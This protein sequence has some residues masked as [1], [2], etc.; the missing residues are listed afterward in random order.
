MKKWILLFL[1]IPSLV[2]A[3]TITISNTGG[4]AGDVTS[5]GDCVS[6]A[7]LDGSS[8]GGTYLRLYDGD[9]HYN[10]L[11][12]PNISGNV[13]ITLPN[14]TGTVL[15]TTGNAA[16]A[17]ALA[18]NGGNCSAG[19]YPLGV[20]ASGAVESC[21]DATTEI[22]SA[23]ATHMAIVTDTSTIGHLN[24]T[25][26]DTFNGKQ[27]ALGF[28]PV[29][30]ADWTT[31]NSYP[32]ACTAGYYAH[33]IGDT[34]SCTDATTEINSVVNGLG[35]TGLTCS[36]Q[37]CDVDL[38]TSIATTELVSPTGADTNVV[39]GTKGS[40]D[41]CAKWNADGDL[42][43]AGAACG[44]GGSGDL[45][46]DAVDAD[47]LPTGADNTYD[48]GSSAASFADIHWDGTATGNVTGNIT[49]NVSGSSG[50]VTTITGLA[51][52]TQNTYARTQYLI[53]VASSTTAFGEIDIGTATHVLT[54]NGAGSA[55]TFQASSGATAYDDIGDP[56][57]NSTI[58]FGDYT[59]TWTTNEAS[60]D[61]FIIQNSGTFGDVS[62]V[63]IE[64]TGNATDGTML[65]IVNTD[66]DV[67]SI[68]APNFTVT[69]PGVVTALEYHG[70][71]SNLTGLSSS[72]G[73]FFHLLPQ[74]GKLPSTDMMAIDAGN[75]QWRGLFDDT[76]DECARWQTT[77]TPYNGGTLQGEIL[78]SLE[79]TSS[80]DVVGIEIYIMCVTGGDAADVDTDSFGTVNDLASG[81]VSTTAG[82]LVK[83][84]DASLNGDS[85]A[86]D[87]LIIVKVCRDAD[88]VDT[89]TDDVEF[90]GGVI[91]E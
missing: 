76:T 73:F 63:K 5:V 50:T 48:L 90:R 40:T 38:G 59:N 24:D 75:N 83:L 8:D 20:D 46:S 30:S 35:G 10:A 67:D 78:Y 15:L 3:G 27:A 25:D 85:C 68:I 79:T 60:S 14:S 62:V 84:S 21:T 77:L 72:A 2:C 4:G 42:V 31:N 44:S 45:W 6:G 9:S 18:A 70:D 54:S 82:Y 12:S 41:D 86:E 81:S 16:T 87:D 1:L 56:D 17:T 51:P 34:L 71:G 53:P 57:A 74:Q 36:G 66:A 55:P 61:F 7:C 26:W 49:G 39:T 11:V 91:Y 29:N 52:D 69:Q 47:I 22:G 58:V 32:A 88:G 37:N 65:E 64:A 89:T 33:T 23:I 28:T 13:T 19:S 43:S 80:S